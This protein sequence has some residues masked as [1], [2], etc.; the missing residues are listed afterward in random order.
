VWI[1]SVEDSSEV[2]IA[3]G[4]AWPVGWSPDGAWVYLWDGDSTPSRAL[5]VSDDGGEPEPVFE[6]PFEG[7][8]GR[9]V[10]GP[11][12]S[13]WLCDVGE[14]SSDIWLV[15]NFDPGMS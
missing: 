6:W 9:C 7:K 13:R 12:E 11:G 3:A 5:R 15:E 2:N 1:I 4:T 10:P 14:S 8:D